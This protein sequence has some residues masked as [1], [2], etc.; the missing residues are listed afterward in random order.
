MAVPRFDAYERRVGRPE[1]QPVI[2]DTADTDTVFY[3][4]V[5]DDLTNISVPLGQE[6]EYKYS[7]TT[8]CVLL[9]FDGE[10]GWDEGYLNI[11]IKNGG[12]T[13]EFI[14]YGPWL[15]I[16]GAGSVNIVYGGI[17]CTKN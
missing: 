6:T 2:A 9:G 13:L 1:C 3:G 4:L 17:V 16:P 7:G 11:A 8:P 10:D 12:K 14:D 15:Y 5:D